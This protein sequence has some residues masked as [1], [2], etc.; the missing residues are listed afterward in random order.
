MYFFIVAVIVEIDDLNRT[1]KPQDFDGFVD[2]TFCSAPHVQE[3]GG[4]RK[5][6][7]GAFQ[8]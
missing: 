1:R 8:N 6:F 5:M 4:T 2:Y 7:L 3:Q